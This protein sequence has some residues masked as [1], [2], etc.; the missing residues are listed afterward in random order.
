MNQLI[1]KMISL[2]RSISSDKGDFSLFAL[3]LRED[4]EDK[5]DLVVSSSWL[6][7][8]KK[9]GIEYL[10]ELLK[11]SLNKAEILSISRIVLIEEDNPGLNAI[12]RAITTEHSGV[13]IKDSNFFGLQIKN[14]Y[15]ITS[16]RNGDIAK[17]KTA[18][19]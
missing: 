8:N 10:A 17:V 12:H 3:F 5:W 18:S 13:E 6:L 2:E 1:E 7:K 14:A 16:K 15:I 4:S 11:K 19:V 9:K